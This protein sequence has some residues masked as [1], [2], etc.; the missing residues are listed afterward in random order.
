MEG[1]TSADGGRV[2]S[3]F[4]ETVRRIARVERAIAS[5]NSAELRD[6]A[7]VAGGGG[8]VIRRIARW[9]ALRRAKRGELSHVHVDEL[10]R[11]LDQKVALAGQVLSQMR[12]DGLLR[13]LTRSR[14]QLQ[15]FLK[16]LRSRRAAKK[17]ELFSETGFEGILGAFPIWLVKLADVHRV[18]PL[19]ENLFDLAIIDEA[20]QCDVPSCL[21][22][23]QRARRV[24][25]AGDL[26][27]LR[28]ISF[29]SRERQR[30]LAGEHRIDPGSPFADYREVS[31]LDLASDRVSSSAQVGFL[32]EHFRSR[33]A[34]IGFS[35]RKFYSGCLNIM[36][37]RAV[38]HEGGC[39][40][41]HRCAGRRDKAGVN[42]VEVD[43]V[44]RHLEELAR[45]GRGFG[46]A[47]CRSVGVLSPFRAQ[48]DAIRE[49]VAHRLGADA[50]DRL[51][52]DHRLLIATAHGFQGEER[53]VMLLSLASGSDGAAQ[54][55]RFLGRPDVLNVA[56][57]RAKV[58]Q[59][60][61]CSFDAESL[62][63]GSLVREYLHHVI[64]GGGIAGGGASGAAAPAVC[65]PFAEEVS[66]ALREMGA[67][68]QHGRALAGLRF[69]L[70]AIRDG[71]A[72]GIDLLGYPGLLEG[73]FPIERYK[74]FR[75]AGMRIFPLAYSQWVVRRDECLAVLG[76]ALAGGG[77]GA[78]SSPAL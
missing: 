21:P 1:G 47:G 27:Q 41:L 16:A 62:P 12:E 26:K 19:R 17:D 13:C 67:A 44:L 4:V 30:R 45:D 35:N 71:D 72:L 7:L 43:A 24:L 29:L 48:V 40:W 31:L 38:P 42:A 69:D 75:R 51:T 23:L 34:I 36:T 20:T 6:G 28:H 65:D 53:D 22:V 11:L 54:S 77:R 3:A 52:G 73:A 66:A 39:L 37:D 15:R 64:R 18:L 46:V 56:V 60:V 2:A 50:F 55:L 25:V 49:E 57:T 10:E 14:P 76:R 61:Y 70:I 32:N 9:F 8:G 5:G 63:Q 74:M 59:H 33:P 58:E 78:T 68:V